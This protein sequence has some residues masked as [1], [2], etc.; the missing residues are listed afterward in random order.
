MPCGEK[1]VSEIPCMAFGSNDSFQHQHFSIFSTTVFTKNKTFI[2]A[3][4]PA[5]ALAPLLA[6]LFSPETLHV[7]SV[8]GA[9]Q[10]IGLLM[11]VVRCLQ[12]GCM[13]IY[14]GYIL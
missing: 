6:H 7:L 4:A 2:P 12:E 13:V 1:S 10:Y 14:F 9:S 3:P 8:F 11:V 5:P